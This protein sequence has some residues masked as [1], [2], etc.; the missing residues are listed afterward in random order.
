MDGCRQV[1]RFP[2]EPGDDERGARA[3]RHFARVVANENSSQV[4]TKLADADA[5]ERSDGAA[6]QQSARALDGCSYARR[7]GRSRD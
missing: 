3:V 1:K 7:P 4:A 5:M 2:S 6:L